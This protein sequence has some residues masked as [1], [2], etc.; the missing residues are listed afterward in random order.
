M[1]GHSFSPSF[2]SVMFP[3][4]ERVGR[5][6]ALTLLTG[7]P[8]FACLVPLTGKVS[9]FRKRERTAVLIFLLSLLAC[10][11][12]WRVVRTF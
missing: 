9:P 11:R 12:D 1:Y 6:V 5:F 7:L 4:M 2:G 10:V 3:F 8:G